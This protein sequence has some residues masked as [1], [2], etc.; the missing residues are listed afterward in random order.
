MK[1][2]IWEFD[3]PISYMFFVYFS[4]WTL[5]ALCVVIWMVVLLWKEMKEP[6]IDML[7][8][9]QYIFIFIWYCFNI[10]IIFCNLWTDLKGGIY[11]NILAWILID[12]ITHYIVI[13][14]LTCYLLMNQIM[15]LHQLRNGDQYQNCK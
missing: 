3:D 14:F 2:G 5:T 7:K 6:F 9:I 4:L 11:L 10:F 1:I 15:V 8:V 12:F 13:N